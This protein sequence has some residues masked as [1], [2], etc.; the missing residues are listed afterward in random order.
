MPDIK[1]TVLEIDTGGAITNIK[2]FKQHIEDLKGKLLGLEKG[3]EEYNTVAKELQSSQQKLNEVM[4]V[5]KGK[6]EAVEG[7]YDNLVATMRELKKA[8]RATGDE[9]ERK[10]LGEKILGINNQLKELD[11]STGNFQRNV[12]NY[13]NSFTDAFN[14][15]STSIG[16]GAI[17]SV[18]GLSAAFKTLLANPVV[19]FLAAISAAIMAVVN[20]IKNSESQLNRMKVAT[21]GVK[22]VIDAFKNVITKVSDAVVTL[23]ENIANLI[24][25]G[26]VKLSSIFRNFGWEKWANGLENF[27]NKVAQYTEEEQ[28]AV[29]LGAKRRKINEEIA[30][31]ENR[32]ASLRAKIADRTKYSEQE[33]LKFID[34]WEKAEKHRAQLAVDLAQEELNIIKAKNAR[35]ENSAKDYDAESDAVVNLTR[36]QGQYEE[37]LRRIN[38]QRSALL[39]GDNSTSTVDENEKAVQQ[40]LNR[41]EEAKKTEIQKLTEKYET[42]KALLI[43]Y[44]KD[45]TDLTAEYEAAVRKIEEDSKKETEQKITEIQKRISDSTK[46]EY[47]IRLENLQERYDTEKEIL[48]ANNEDITALEAYY[49]SERQKILDEQQAKEDERRAAEI[50]KERQSLEEKRNLQLDFAKSSASILSSAGDAWMNYIKAQ[51][52][53]GKMS[54]E[55]G[56]RQFEAAKALQISSAII[57]TIAGAVGAFMGITK[58][59]GGW[60]IAAAAATA[61]AVTAAGVAQ[62]A[63]IANTKLGDTA[64]NISTPNVAEIS[65]DYTP[66][67]VQNVTADT[68]LSELTNAVNNRIAYVSVTDIEDKQNLVKVRDTESTY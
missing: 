27:T 53:S 42:E 43:Q 24:N 58:D 29:D 15:L 7:S 33:R 5:A 52:E 17:P 51:V 65:N 63:T 8:W 20:S 48:V 13:A 3:T 12:G 35:T 36:A 2:D 6:G 18:K 4:D 45:T 50:E 40:I 38:Q 54:K 31:T 14:K 55:E 21:A 67:Y 1:T 19:A 28:K 37:S 39:R 32:V 16:G 59:T 47:Q 11:A 62:I 41:L 30:R 44:G 23:T 9:V 10:Q 49:A 56:E 57:N 64:S 60:G 61:A 26:L 22:V 25:N 68:E 46:N 66:E 34:D